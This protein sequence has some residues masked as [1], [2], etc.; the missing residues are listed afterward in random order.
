MGFRQWKKTLKLSICYI[1]AFNGSSYVRTNKKIN[2]N[3]NDN[4][5]LSASKT[6][7]KTQ[8]T[9]ID[10]ILT[11]LNDIK[12]KSLDI[13]PLMLSSVKSVKLHIAHKV[14]LFF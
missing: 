6:C 14:E 11:P 2:I 10:R 5:Q 13:M 12:E 7:Y 3:I 8:N 9:K 4:V 1:K